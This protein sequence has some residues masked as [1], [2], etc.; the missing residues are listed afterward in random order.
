MTR[1]SQFRPAPPP[2][3]DSES[4]T[5]GFNEI[6]EIG[7]LNSKTRTVEQTEIEN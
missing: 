2:A 3:L 5:R 4:W 7:A 6:G 1:D